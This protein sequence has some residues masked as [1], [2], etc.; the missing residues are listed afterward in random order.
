MP[1]GVP[2][3]CPLPLCVQ[4]KG[5]SEEEEMI[6]HD[7]EEGKEGYVP[8]DKTNYLPVRPEDL[9]ACQRLFRLP[10]EGEPIHS[11]LFFSFLFLL[12]TF[13]FRACTLPG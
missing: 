10:K 13:C 8:P 3:V 11:F 4:V 1:S 6:D 9:S 12:F 2:L 7:E 5:D